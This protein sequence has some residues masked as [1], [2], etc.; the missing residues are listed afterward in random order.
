MQITVQEIQ[1]IVSNVTKVSIEEINSPSRKGNVVLSRHLSMH[2]SRWNTK[3]PMQKIAKL[4]N[5]DYH[6]TVIN[7]DESISYSIRKDVKLKTIYD[8]IQSQIKNF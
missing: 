1:Q 7:A 2:F 5:R 3:L 8:E 4:H 6:A